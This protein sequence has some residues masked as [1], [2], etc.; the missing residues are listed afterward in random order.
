MLIWVWETF[1]AIFWFKYLKFRSCGAWRGKAT[2]ISFFHICPGGNG[3]SAGIFS[4]KWLRKCV[5]R[6]HLPYIASGGTRLERKTP[7]GYCQKRGTYTKLPPPIFLPTLDKWRHHCGSIPI[8]HFHSCLFS[9]PPFSSHTCLVQISGRSSLAWRA[10]HMCWVHCRI[11]IPIEMSYDSGL[12]RSS[13]TYVCA[14]YICLST[15]HWESTCPKASANME[16]KKAAHVI[17]KLSK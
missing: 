1:R 5:C 8:Q 2:L 14:V 4:W 16:G 11:Y 6:L 9:I 13:K 7:K 10:R 12:F 17:R 3:I 15:F